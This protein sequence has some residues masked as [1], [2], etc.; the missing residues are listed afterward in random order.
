M[1][2]CVDIDDV[3]CETAASLCGLAERAFGRRV[4]Y[5]EVREFDLQRVFALT[6]AEMR[7]FMALSHEPE[8][9]MSYPE[10]PGASAGL[11]RLRAAGCE[12]DIVTG[13]PAS[14][15]AAT[16]AWL[17]SVGLAGFAVTFVD[18]YGRTFAKG[19]DDPPTV[20]L[21]EFLRRDYDFAIDDSPVVLPSFA[22]WTRT[23]VLVFDRPWN[24]SFALAPNM[25]RVSGW[26][27]IV[28]TVTGQI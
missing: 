6:D 5:R 12:I 13:R 21:A 2:V 23:G 24:A 11:R 1:R 27:D 14:S 9:L 10:T 25:R 28:R 17:E 7:R 20:P 4:P 18:K 16:V 26:D 15:H 8:T 3:L 22:D 19:P